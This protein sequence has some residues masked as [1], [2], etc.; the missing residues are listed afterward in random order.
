MRKKNII[1]LI[2]PTHE[3]NL[4]CEY[5]YD[6]V[7]K[8]HIKNK[9]IS[10]DTIKDTVEKVFRG[11]E[12]VTLI[13]HGGEALL[14]G[15]DFFYKA[16]DAINEIAKN[17]DTKV[18]Y[19]L[20]TNGLLYEKNKKMLTDLNIKVSTSLD[21]TN[22]NKYRSSEDTFEYI[23]TV[24]EG[25][26]IAP[27]NVISLED[28]EKLIEIYEHT[29]ENNSNVSFNK[30]FLNNE[31][32]E[33]TIKFANN[34]NKYID[35]VLFDKDAFYLERS[36]ED[37]LKL[38]LGFEKEVTCSSR[39][40]LKDFISIN[41]D[42]DIFICDRFG[43]S[44]SGNYGF[45][46]IKDINFTILEFWETDI[47]KKIQRDNEYFEKEFCSKCKINFICKGTCKSNRTDNSDKI[48][49][50]IQNNSDCIFKQITYM[51]LLDRL[52][53]LTEEEMLNLNPIV[54]RN[55]FEHNFINKYILD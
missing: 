26:K 21:Y 30:R 28:S 38:I 54:Y 35:H 50:K 45:I 16:H 10:L 29:K 41:P 39:N 44:N 22:K 40:C 9:F 34:Y 43:V 3:C 51:H 25:N 33:E 18:D 4:S 31:T 1:L 11:Y 12:D 53:H 6:K 20:Q 24:S 36:F 42:G 7:E 13:W 46:N 52:Y 2:K 19:F 37:I 55:L 47:F 32:E 15:E 17:N 5:C 49:L 14:A 48:N 27:I 8:Q 23:K